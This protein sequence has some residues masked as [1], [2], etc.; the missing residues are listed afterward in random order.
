MNYVDTK[1]NLRWCI[2]PDVNTSYTGA[3]A[4]IAWLGNGW[5]FPTIKELDVLYQ[6]GVGTRNI[7]PM[8]SPFSGWFVWSIPHESWTAWGFYFAHGKEHW[9]ARD[10]SYGSRVFAIMEK[11]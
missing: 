7:D 10:N 5:R 6:E 1:T 3:E 2:G 11:V 4:F 8:F 9:R